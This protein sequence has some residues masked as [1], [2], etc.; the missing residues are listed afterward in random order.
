MTTNSL[1]GSKD[2]PPSPRTEPCEYDSC[3]PA[4]ASYGHDPT[5]AR[6]NWVNSYPVTSMKYGIYK[7][8][9]ALS[10]GKYPDLAVSGP[11]VGPNVG[12]AIPVSGTVGAA[13]YAAHEA[14]IP[15]I[16]FSGW[17]NNSAWNATRPLSSKL[18]ASAASK[19]IKHLVAQG[20]P[21]LPKNVWLNVN[22]PHANET[23]CATAK[24][25][26]FVLA[27]MEDLGPIS[28]GCGLTRLPT[29]MSVVLH[30]GCYASVT[31]AVAPEKK[32]ASAAIRQA[33]ADRLKGLL[34]DFPD[35]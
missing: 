1:E 8:T 9:P 26:T 33:V 29:E 2:E 7:F 34:G 13:S 19:L 3:T 10:G 5:N 22:F 20:R 23:S 11:N 28:K 30:S 16:A 18:D 12:P 21:F 24:D 17:G 35:V 15:A 27:T 25:V 14:G 32:D 4:G 6:L 31:V